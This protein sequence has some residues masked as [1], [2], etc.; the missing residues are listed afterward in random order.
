[1]NRQSEAPNDYAE[2]N[3]LAWWR[4]VIAAAL[5]G[6][7]VILAAISFALAWVEE[8][9][10]LRLLCAQA[11]LFFSFLAAYAAIATGRR[12]R[13]LQKELLFARL[14]ERRQSRKQESSKI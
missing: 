10:T 8:V 12:W 11:T 7:F 6:C 1:M 9:T 13:L 2:Q 14:R 3:S 4:Y 5:S